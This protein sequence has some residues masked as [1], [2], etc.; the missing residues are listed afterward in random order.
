MN[1]VPFD[2]WS[3]S[4]QKKRLRL[5]DA[6]LT[7]EWAAFLLRLWPSGTIK[8]PSSRDIDLDELYDFLCFLSESHD[9]PDRYVEMFA[10]DILVQWVDTSDPR[11][12]LRYQHGDPLTVTVSELFA[13]VT[14]SPQLQKDRAWKMIASVS[15]AHRPRL[16][17]YH[18]AQ[19]VEISQ[20]EGVLRGGFDQEYQRI[21]DQLSVYLRW[22]IEDEGRPYYPEEKRERDRRSPESAAGGEAGEIEFEADFPLED[23]EDGSEPA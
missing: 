20:P 8:V 1:G 2:S 15:E 3:R 18:D 21:A 9:R 14:S 19:G 12:P 16:N 11:T 23:D 13:F 6:A 7:R 5:C 17:V 4:N 22:K 10:Y